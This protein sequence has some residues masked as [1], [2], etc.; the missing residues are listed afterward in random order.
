M[1]NGNAVGGIVGYG[2]TFVL[3]D[4]SGNE[5]TGVVVDEEVIF[6]ADPITDIREGKVA[7]TDAGVVTGAKD[8]PAYR[9]EQGAYMIFDGD[10]FMLDDMQE[11]N[12]YDYTQLQCIIAPFNTTPEDSVASD[13]I[14]LNNNVYLTNSATP[15]ASVTKDLENKLIKLNITNNSGNDYIIHY[16]TYREEV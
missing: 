3:T 11:Y 1:I 16:F 7:A 2:K 4:E 13:K 12:Q 9:T 15:F 5:L 14:V 6:T 10:E 8:I